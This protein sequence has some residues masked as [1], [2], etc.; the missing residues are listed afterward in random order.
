M[1]EKKINNNFFN[2]FNIIKEFVEEENDAPVSDVSIGD[3]QLGIHFKV[4]DKDYTIN[5]IEV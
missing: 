2:M 5:L 1:K 3:Q 4:E